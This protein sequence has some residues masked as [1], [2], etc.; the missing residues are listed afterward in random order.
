MGQVQC[1]NFHIGVPLGKIILRCTQIAQI[2]T[3]LKLLFKKKFF[4]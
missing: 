4:S 3:C 1:Y 2:W